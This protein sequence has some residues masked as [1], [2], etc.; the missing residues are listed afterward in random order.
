MIIGSNFESFEY[1][2][3]IRRYVLREG[4]M[5][6]GRGW[7][8]LIVAGSFP[9]HPTASPTINQDKCREIQWYDDVY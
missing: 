1:I 2:F 6:L 4:I 7:S 3:C 9:P 8:I 5:P